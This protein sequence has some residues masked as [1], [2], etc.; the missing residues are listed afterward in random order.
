MDALK[1]LI[2]I[3]T[4]I[5]LCLTLAGCASGPSEN[6]EG[7]AEEHEQKH[8]SIEYQVSE[9]VQHY[10]Q[11]DSKGA[12]YRVAV[13]ADTDADELK[14]VFLD[15]VAQDDFDVHTV[16]FYSDISLADGSAPCDVATA[17]QEE[18][19]GDPTVV[20]SSDDAK[21]KAQKALASKS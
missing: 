3:A 11:G 14:A 9:D 13:P 8:A 17:I 2:A 18:P 5:S 1:K 7:D 16:W 19:G 6:Q 21:A 12:S 15:V 4:A 20:L 10:A